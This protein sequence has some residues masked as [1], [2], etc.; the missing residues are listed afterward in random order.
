MDK[1][2]QLSWEEV[3][4]IL[5]RGVDVWS[6]EMAMRWAR[7]TFDILRES[8]L[9]PEEPE[10]QRHRALARV[11]AVT[12][13]YMNF[14]RIA[15]EEP[16]WA[17][18][19]HYID[20]DE[21]DPFI[22]GQLYARTPEW[23]ADEPPESWEG[24]LEAIVDAERETVVDALLEGFGDEWQLFSALWQS[25]AESEEDLDRAEHCPGSQ[26][27]RARVMGF[28]WVSSGCPTYR[29]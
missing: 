6:G 2:S 28:D 18:Y 11:L 13:V 19:G 10:F 3:A 26:G 23:D 27:G 5:E 16:C 1:A 25:R 20:G 7:R 15:W 8:E 22:M 9:L 24:A 21:F 14:C 12:G 29:Y 4:Y 17:T